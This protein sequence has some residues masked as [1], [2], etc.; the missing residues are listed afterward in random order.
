M[1]GAMHAAKMAFRQVGVNLGC[2]YVAMTQ[3][4]LHRP[5]IGA[6]FQQMGREA[7]AQGMRADP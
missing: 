7:V 1:I 2:G 6:A 3:H 5:Q 4:L